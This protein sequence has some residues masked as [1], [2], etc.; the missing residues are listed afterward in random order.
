MLKTMS[1]LAKYSLLQILQRA[2][3]AAKPAILHQ[4]IRLNI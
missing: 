1:A 4:V 2:V 3:K